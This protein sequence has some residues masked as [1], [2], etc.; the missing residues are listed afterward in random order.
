[1]K[2]G[3]R[4][5]AALA[6]AALVALAG[7]AVSKQPVSVDVGSEAQAGSLVPSASGAVGRV[8]DAHGRPVAQAV[9]E[10]RSLERPP[11][12]LPQIGVLSGADGRFRWPLPPGRHALRARLGEMV[13][14]EVAAA[15]DDG[16]ATL[17]LEAPPPGGCAPLPGPR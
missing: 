15:A 13:S 14:C 11:R 6:P 8:V 7:C 12:P 2:R 9:I 16:V 4:C 10:A 3:A 5:L 17:V 1:M